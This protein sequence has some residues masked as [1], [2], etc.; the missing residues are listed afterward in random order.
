VRD[1]VAGLR[2]LGP[3]LGRALAVFTLVAAHSWALA[4]TT[5]SGPLEVNTVWRAQDGPFDIADNLTIRGGATLAV[6]A[7]TQIFLRAGVNLI[8]QQGSLRVLGTAAAPV[9]FTSQRDRAG[10]TPAPGDWGQL[11]FLDGA[12]DAG[13]RLEH[14]IFRFG[15]GLLIERASPRLDHLQIDLN[16]G[17]AISM[18]LASSPVGEGLAA[19]GNALDGILVPAGEVRGEVVWGLVG[20]PYVV[21]SGQVSVGAAPV[22]QGLS[23]SRIEQ[24]ETVT[25][26][27]TGSRLGG[28]YGA[29]FS[30]AGVSGSV[31]PGGTDSSVRLEV[32][33]APSAALGTAAFELLTGA[34]A[35]PFASGLAVVPPLPP[36]ALTAVEPASIRQGE[37]LA[38]TLTGS[39]LQGATISTTQPGLS[40]SALQTTPTQAR[41]DL[42]AAPTATLGQALLTA[43]NPG[44]AKGVA[45]IAIEVRRPLPKL[46][47]T[48]AVLAV[49]P[50]GAPRQFRVGLTA[51]DEVD[52]TITL[53]LADPAVATVAP[54]SVTLAA[55]QTEQLVSLRGLQLGQTSL[56]VTVPGLAPLTVPVYVTP[57]FSSINVAYARQVRV[58]RARSGPPA[59]QPV[60]PLLSRAV[61]VG[62]RRFV[63]ST[64][65]SALGV[66]S[67]PVEVVLSG[68]GLEGVTGVAFRPA[69]GVTI[70]SVSA[71]PDGRSVRVL[72]TVASDASLG[73]RQVV[74]AGIHQPYTFLAGAD[75][76]LIV[77]PAPEIVSVNPIAVAPGAGATAF[78]VRGRHLQNLQALAFTPAA[79]IVA[80]VPAVSADGTVLTTTLTVAAD[81]PPGDRL[82]SVTTPAGST[83]AAPSPANTLRVVRTLG[84]PVGLLSASAR[85]VRQAGAPPAATVAGLPSREVRLARG[86]VASRV[87]PGAG[88]I[89]ET[90]VLSI[91]GRGLQEVTQV[92]LEPPDGISLGAVQPA[93]DGSSVSVQTTIAADAAR[94]ARRV[95]V[96]VGGQEI[97]FA[98][99]NAARFRVT[100]PLPQLVGI[101]P[102]AI[103]AGGGPMELRLVG[104]NLQ[105]A[106]RVSV[107][108]PDGISVSAPS[109]VNATGTEA[110]VSISASAAAAPGPRAVL[111]ATPAGESD[112]AATLA[113]TLTVAGTL[114]P[115]VTP[116]ASRNVRVLR[117]ELGGPTPRAVGPTLSRQV[118]VA[119]AAAPPPVASAA[120]V[121]SR[122]VPLGKGAVATGVSP[123]GVARGTGAT[124]VVSGVG[125]GGVTGVALVP[126]EGVT[127]GTLERA[128]DGTQ[129]SVPLTVAVDAAPGVRG[130][131]LTA[132]GAAVA[133][134]KPGAAQ[135]VLGDAPAIDSITPIVARRG[136][137][138]TL[139][140]RGRNLRGAT[141]EAQP[142]E[143]LTF[144]PGGTVNAAATELAVQVA[145][146]ADAGLGARTI[147]VRTPAGVSTAQAGPNNTFSIFP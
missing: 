117:D 89:G 85:V 107:V 57:D 86:S 120:L 38:F 59:Q 2:R 103:Q 68:G 39:Q 116:L 65:P 20:I 135:I 75:R 80:G 140:I 67:G 138:L 143:G 136:E 122:G 21:A 130:I 99:A 76:V 62:A 13:T 146:S 78:T 144:A 31:L 61:T 63:Q 29:R 72:A 94:T 33:A 121:T 108:P 19:Q 53:A 51:A 47:V 126:P 12:S 84:A 27:A 42:T 82:V 100:V 24:G 34:G 127:L 14:A 91:A 128:A 3:K 141:V 133:F 131:R 123:V 110:T 26:T 9:L 137:T 98:D 46:L 105:N 71:A 145:V 4:A 90:L 16:A 11:R 83:S 22:V 40:V 45:S 55:G 113:N 5:V 18:D 101:A 92:R 73:A 147:R 41:F 37:K 7:G 25:V 139:L 56:S 109:G 102:I 28:A 96:F 81:A 60:S 132:A 52:R 118:S 23:P 1:A 48:P 69:T 111:I 70:G 142:A 93:A 32:S 88:S 95:R 43:A 50:D 119:R 115:P 97:A 17:P 106:E 35:A 64:A 74:L 49:P 79:G 104:R 6:E 54:A 58:E 44:V 134:V 124:L 129:I 10:D 114:S 87:T 66:G 36:I 15:Q 30:A 8:V 125:L 112:A 77:P